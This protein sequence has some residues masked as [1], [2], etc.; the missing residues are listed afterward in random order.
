MANK[1]LS[2]YISLVKA[3]MNEARTA[4][5]GDLAQRLW[6]DEDITDALNEAQNEICVELAS[7]R[8]FFK[9]TASIDLVAG[10]LTLPDDI[11]VGLGATLINTNVT[12]NVRMRMDIMS[13]GDL[14]NRWPY[15]RSTEAIQYPTTLVQNW[16][17]AGAEWVTYP[18]A[19]GTIADAILLTYVVRPTEMVDSDDTSPVADCF[20]SLQRSLLPFCALKN[21]VLYEAGEND[22]QA[23]KFAMLY[24][25]AIGQ[26]HQFLNASYKGRLQYGLRTS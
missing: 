19:T 11:L 25:Q 21:L 26:C 18:Q 9:T 5:S 12:P 17:S 13:M 10:A 15:W 4:S 6:P 20:P 23:A 14:D 2:D 3:Y 1:T 16:S 8:D 24:T 22:Q 7:T